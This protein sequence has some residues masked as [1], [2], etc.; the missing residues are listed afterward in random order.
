MRL[1]NYKNFLQPQ[2]C[3]NFTYILNHLRLINY[4]TF[5][6]TW[7]INFTCILKTFE[8]K[9][10]LWQGIFQL[11]VTCNSNMPQGAFSLKFAKKCPFYL[12]CLKNGS[13]FAI[14]CIF[15]HTHILPYYFVILL[16][17]AMYEM[18]L[19]YYL[20]LRPHFWKYGKG[21][22][23]KIWVRCWIAAHFDTVFHCFSIA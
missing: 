17:Y 15:C 22:H 19:A 6:Q 9:N 4:K 7:W 14:F 2:Q 5:L 1:I 10:Y 12:K 18:L 11:S 13:Y 3:I 23:G 16:E 20:M 8:T 21:R